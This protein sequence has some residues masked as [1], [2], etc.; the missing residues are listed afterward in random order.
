[1]IRGKKEIKTLDD[2]I[3]FMNDIM[4][5]FEGAWQFNHQYQQVLRIHREN[6]RIENKLDQ[7]LDRMKYLTSSDNEKKYLNLDGST[8][9]DTICEMC[10]TILEQNKK[11]VIE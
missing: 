11:E 2:V 9:Y 3:V 5:D 7:V 8:N 10:D 6:V 4:E 1:M